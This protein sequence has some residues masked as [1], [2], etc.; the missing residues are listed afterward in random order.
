MYSDVN[1]SLRGYGGM[2]LPKDTIAIASLN[3]KIKYRFT[4]NTIRPDDNLK[5][6]KTVSQ[7]DERIMLEEHLGGPS[8]KHIQM[9]VL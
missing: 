4:I 1:P 2:C 7:R 9:K 3:E 8:A 6:K 5:F